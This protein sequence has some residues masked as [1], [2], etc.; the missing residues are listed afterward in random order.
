[1]RT[2][3]RTFFETMAV[4]KQS[5]CAYCMKMP[6]PFLEPCENCKVYRMFVDARHTFEA[7]TPEDEKQKRYETHAVT[8]GMNLPQELI[9]SIGQ[10]SYTENGFRTSARYDICDPNTQSVQYCLYLEEAKTGFP[11]SEGI[12][13]E[14]PP[15]RSTVYYLHM[16]PTDKK[17]SADIQIWDLTCHTLRK[18]LIKVLGDDV[19]YLN[20]TGRYHNG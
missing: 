8:A 13:C 18:A 6:M 19:G 4:A 3:P 10:G 17:G 12:P 1:M 2:V 16:E 5:F 9:R 7:E 14:E 11:D 15:S 20:V